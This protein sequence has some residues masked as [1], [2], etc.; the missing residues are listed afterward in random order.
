M[1]HWN[2]WLLLFT[3]VSIQV[4]S[5][6]VCNSPIQWLPGVAVIDERHIMTDENIVFNVDSLTNKRMAGD[7]TVSS[8]G[9]PFL[10]L[11]KGSILVWSQFHIHTDLQNHKFYIFSQL[12]IGAIFCGIGLMHR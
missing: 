7:F 11:H 4:Q 5:A 2:R 9:R 8:D 3:W 12:D 1:W 10:D 6:S